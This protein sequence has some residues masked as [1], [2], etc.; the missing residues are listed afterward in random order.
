MTKRI[1]LLLIISLTLTS[2]VKQIDIPIEL[3]DY[4]IIHLSDTDTLTPGNKFLSSHIEKSSELYQFMKLH[5]AP[6]AYSLQGSYFGQ[7]K[8]FLYYPNLE[9]TFEAIS[10]H[11][12]TIV[13]WRI[14]PGSSELY[15][16]RK[17]EFLDIDYSNYYPVFN[18]WNTKFQFKDPVVTIND[19]QKKPIKF[20]SFR[21]KTEADVVTYTNKHASRFS[22]DL[23]ERANNGDLRHRV[24]QE[25]ASLESLSSWYTGSK[26]NAAK[27]ASYNKISGKRELSR[28]I[29][30]L[31]PAGLVTNEKIM[32][33]NKQK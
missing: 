30:V 10:K 13:L 18:L 5:G 27:I 3:I 21:A 26:D 19:F 1:L 25:S 16:S 22:N 20:K 7:V 17:D 28:G 24:K 12:Q 15:E 32:L 2:C 33:P 14:K 31:I 4:D 9:A 6:A 11:K 8:M 23:A 29:L